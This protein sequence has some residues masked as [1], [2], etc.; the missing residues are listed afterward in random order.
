MCNTNPTTECKECYCQP[1]SCPVVTRPTC[2]KN[3]TLTCEVD[4]RGCESCACT[5]IK[6]EKGTFEGVWITAD[7]GGFGYFAQMSESNISCDAIFGGRDVADLVWPLGREPTWVSPPFDKGMRMAWISFEGVKRGPGS[8]GVNGFR[9]Q[10]EVARLVADKPDVMRKAI[11]RCFGPQCG[12]VCG[13][14]CPNGNKLDEFGCPL[15]ECLP[16]PC[17]PL[18]CEELSCPGG[19]NVS[20]TGCQECKCKP[21]TP[22]CKIQTLRSLK[23]EGCTNL[24]NN[25]DYVARTPTEWND[26]YKKVCAGKNPPPSVNFDTEMVVGILRAGNG[27]AGDAYITEILFCDGKEYTA[28]VASYF[29]GP[30]STQII[31]RDFV[32]IPKGTAPIKFT[33]GP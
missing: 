8:F 32:A 27:C 11:T 13:I 16:A 7:F 24:S 6:E 15:C 20:S 30:C 23:L 4:R 9:Y 18:N 31:A 33:S 25:G 22:T 10:Y 5:P 12:P 28:K 3:E 2:A 17:Q 29:D 1:A 26:V 14:F 19:F 21:G